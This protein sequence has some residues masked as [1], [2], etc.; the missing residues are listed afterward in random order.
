MLRGG[1]GFINLNGEYRRGQET[2]GNDTQAIIVPQKK[3][4]RDFIN[5]FDLAGLARFT[6]FN[7][8]PADAFASALA[9]QGKQYAFYMF[10]GT[11][12]GKWGAHFIAKPA[13]YRDTITLKAIPPA[14]Y[15]LEWIDPATGIV[16]GTEDISW[17]GGDLTVTTPVY[18]IDVALEIRQ[19]SK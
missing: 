2:G 15:R 4:L 11:N 10:H 13:S 14:T 8:V 5:R 7:G 12:D 17:A 1:A 18:S 3:I 6:N 9:E 19:A 16:K